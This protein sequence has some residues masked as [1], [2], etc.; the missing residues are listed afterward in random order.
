DN[1]NYIIDPHGAIGCLALEDYQNKVENDSVGVVLETAHP[2]KF[3]DV[4]EKHLTIKPE[5][6]ERLAS[7]LDKKGS[8]IKVSNNYNDFKEILQ[9]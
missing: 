9:K 3:L 7:C 8:T 2:A 6:P 4:F 1:Y 5:I